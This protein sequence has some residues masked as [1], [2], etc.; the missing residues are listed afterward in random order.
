[1]SKATRTLVRNKR[2]KTFNPDSE[3][4]KKIGVEIFRITP[5]QFRLQRGLFKID[6]YPTSG[7]FFDISAKKWGTIPAFDLFKLFKPAKE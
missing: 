2:I 5:W 1:M 6:Y 3:D 7:K 4:W